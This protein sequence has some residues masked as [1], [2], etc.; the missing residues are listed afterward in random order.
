M[1]MLCARDVRSRVAD[2]EL[3]YKLENIKP[4]CLIILEINS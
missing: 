2:D 1:S 4:L 3:L